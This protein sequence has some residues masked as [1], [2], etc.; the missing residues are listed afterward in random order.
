MIKVRPE[1]RFPC[2]QWQFLSGVEAQKALECPNLDLPPSPLSFPRRLD[3]LLQIPYPATT[4]TSTRPISS[5]YTSVTTFHSLSLLACLLRLRSLDLCLFCFHLPA[6]GKQL[7][8]DSRICPP[9]VPLLLQHSTR[10]K[11]TRNPREGTPNSPH[12]TH[13]QVAQP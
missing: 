4:S 13:T 7:Q 1:G 3:L 6:T 11:T 10:R 9:R 12:G 8:G 2:Q 5:P